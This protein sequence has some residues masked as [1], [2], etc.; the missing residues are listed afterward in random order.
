MVEL[1]KRP[2]RDPPA[3][4]PA[5]KRS[6]AKA[7]PATAPAEPAAESSTA[8]SA[9]SAP[10]GVVGKAKRAASKVKEAIAG[11]LESS[12]AGAT[13]SA[14]K[15]PSVEDQPPAAVESGEAGVIPETAGTA[16][17]TTTAPSA[18]TGAADTGASGTAT[19]P[20]AL[21]SA[22]GKKMRQKTKALGMGV[23]STPPTAQ[24]PAAAPEASTEAT[25]STG[26]AAPA[27]TVPRSPT[28]D[29]KAIRGKG[30]TTGATTGIAA[31][32]PMAATNADAAAAPSATEESR[33]PATEDLENP[34]EKGKV[35]TTSTTVAQ[36]TTLEPATV[37]LSTASVGKIVPNLPTFG[38]TL[39]SHTGNK[40]TFADL[41]TQSTS[42]LIIFTYPRASTPGCTQQACAFRDNHD[43]FT[44]D[45]GFAVYGLSTDSAKANTTFA[46]KQNLQYPLLCDAAAS[47]TGAL[48]MKKAGGAKA[49]TLRGVVVVDKAGVVKVWFQGGPG[50]TVDAVKEFLSAAK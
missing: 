18:E 47:L 32:P 15:Q 13:E 50:K 14:A 4:A 49:G 22:D 10:T 35:D 9:T 27:A 34:P 46:T 36:S 31:A 23:T 7:T 11:P 2:Q 30:K 29:A 24:A 12:E 43:A 48:G 28:A 38:G 37:P 26:D 25:T 21:S 5:P 8:T 39:E 44:K 6:K 3:P 17:S 42:G 1:R 20:P 16:P 41:L 19:L 45:S 40:V 33:P